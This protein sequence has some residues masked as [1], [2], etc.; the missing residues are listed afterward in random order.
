MD[1]LECSIC[2]KKY[3]KEINS[4][5][6]D[7]EKKRWLCNDCMYNEYYEGNH[8]S[9]V[10]SSCESRLSPRGAKRLGQLSTSQS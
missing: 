9:A 5:N 10:K 4:L 2:G 8:I 1:K 7:R 6:L 3:P